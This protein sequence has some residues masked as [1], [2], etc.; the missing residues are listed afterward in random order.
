VAYDRYFVFVVVQLSQHPGVS[1][2]RK[3]HW[4][5]QLFWAYAVINVFY[6]LFVLKYVKETKGQTIEQIEKNA[7]L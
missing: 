7:N 3:G 1:H 4:Y 6:M 2:A 5:T